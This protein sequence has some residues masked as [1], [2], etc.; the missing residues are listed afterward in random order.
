M[1]PDS[2]NPRVTRGR[3]WAAA[4]KHTSGIAVM[5]PVNTISAITDITTTADAAIRTAPDTAPRSRRR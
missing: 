4:A 2:S 5:G 1:T 3:R